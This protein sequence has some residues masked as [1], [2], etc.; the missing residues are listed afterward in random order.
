MKKTLLLSALIVNALLLSGCIAT[1]QTASTVGTAMNVTN[2]RRSTGEVIDDKTIGLRLLTWS[3][4][5]AKL[6]DAHVNFMSFDR[7][8][9]ATG[10]VPNTALRNYVVQQVQVVD[11]KIEN[12]INEINI[13]PKSGYL[14]RAKD[15]AITAQIEVRFHDQEVF[16]PIHVKVMT[17]AQVVYL[18]GKVTQREA[19]QAAKIAAKTKGV[20]KVVKLFNYL[21]ARPAAEIERDKQRAIEAQRQAEAKKKQAE[22]EAK[23]AELKRQLRELGAPT[24]GT[25]F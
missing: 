25:V 18:M 10:E 3:T 22:I 13:G 4:E 17:E 24:D 19:E 9:L 5:D 23:K 15:V 8:V 16:H 2:E 12:V 1:I 20:R 6:K 11:P 14:S 7:T 21:K